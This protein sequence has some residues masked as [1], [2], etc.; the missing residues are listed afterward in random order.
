MKYKLVIS[1]IEN[2]KVVDVNIK[3]GTEPLHVLHELAICY[4]ECSPKTSENERVMACKYW[5]STDQEVGHVQHFR[6]T[7]RGYAPG[8][9]YQYEYEFKGCNL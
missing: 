2:K 6:F 1:Q 5:V 9:T 3:E 7:C 4:R 8:I